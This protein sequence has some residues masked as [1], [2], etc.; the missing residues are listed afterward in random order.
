M[1]DTLTTSFSVTLTEEDRQKTHRYL[2]ET[3]SHTP[4]SHEKGSAT[5]TGGLTDHQ[6]ASGINSILIIGEESSTFTIKVGN[7]TATPFTNM[8]VFMYDGDMIDIFISNPA[9]DPI[10]VNYVTGKF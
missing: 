3:V 1:A 2:D 9:V 10:K 5:L 4:V 7:T 8:K 6:L